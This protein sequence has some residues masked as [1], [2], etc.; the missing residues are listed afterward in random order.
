MAECLDDDD[1]PVLVDPNAQSTVPCDDC[2]ST[3]DV[4]SYCVDC[5]GALCEK[6]KEGHQR[7]KMTR[8]HKVVD[9][10]DPI[11]ENS[12]KV[13][14]LGKCEK[15]PGNPMVSY[16]DK[17]GRPC[18]LNC[19]AA[20]HINHQ[21]KDIFDKYKDVKASVEKYIQK[22]E[23]TV[24]ALSDDIRQTEA[25]IEY[26]IASA[27][28]LEKQLETTLKKIQAAFTKEGNKLRERIRA[29]KEENIASLR[30]HIS[31]RDKEKSQCQQMI[32]E[33]NQFLKT[34]F[35]AIVKFDVEK[36]VQAKYTFD[37]KQRPVYSLSEGE[38]DVQI[39]SQMIG[40]LR[41]LKSPLL[42]TKS[43]ATPDSIVL[44]PP[45]V[46]DRHSRIPP[47]A[48]RISDPYRFIGARRM[49]DG[50]IF[51][52]GKV[53]TQLEWDVFRQKNN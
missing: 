1:I 2:E 25:D 7:R 30:G 27:A 5:P 14:A 31:K 9:Y 10:T 41:L 46:L 6:C 36:P 23:S 39:I 12:K 44:F 42:F 35:E 16:C 50:T 32:V 29:Q 51:Y 15:H 11:V 21:T 13:A 8:S 38:I 17:C 34:D 37:Q 28:R 4:F 18:C 40:E 45:K 3:E 20:D 52:N 48:Y 53:Y 22:N 43:E 19:L 26:E 49:G 33:G 24:K 47:G